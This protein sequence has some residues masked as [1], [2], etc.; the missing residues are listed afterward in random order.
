MDRPGFEHCDPFWLSRILVAQ[1]TRKLEVLALLAE[2]LMSSLS[3]LYIAPFQSSPMA[4]W[5]FCSYD[6]HRICLPGA[7][8][9]KDSDSSTADETRLKAVDSGLLVRICGLGLRRDALSTSTR[10]AVPGDASVG[11]AIALWRSSW[12]FK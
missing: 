7:L 9:C 4:A 2:L 10:N 8:A 1:G 5:A 6:P 3:G 11:A 12:W